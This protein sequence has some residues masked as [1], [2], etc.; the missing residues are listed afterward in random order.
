MSEPKRVVHSDQAPKAIGPYSQAVVVDGWVF[1]S[2]Q[3]GLDP[4]TGELVA[5]GVAAQ[6]EQAM[7]NI[8][9][10]L[11]AAGVGFDQVVKTTIFLA[12]MGDFAAVNEVYGKRFAGTKPARSTVAAKTLPKGALVEVDYVARV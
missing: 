5:G 9:A 4:A 10:V 12:D 8:A 2:G 11:Q 3:I 7:K 6:A 1:G